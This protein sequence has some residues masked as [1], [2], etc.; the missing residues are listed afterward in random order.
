[1]RSLAVLPFSVVPLVLACSIASPRG[2]GVHRLGLPDGSKVQVELVEYAG[3]WGVQKVIPGRFVWDMEGGTLV[4][5]L[6]PTPP[7]PPEGGGQWVETAVNGSFNSTTKSAQVVWISPTNRATAQEFALPQS[8]T[9]AVWWYSWSLDRVLFVGDT[10][11]DASYLAACS[12]ETGRCETSLLDGHRLSL[13][14]DRTVTEN[15]LRVLLPG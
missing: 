5:T 2:V 1:M 9:S 6:G 4:R 11:G 3:D 13:D 8:A 7:L 12:P 15:L 14:V 10:D